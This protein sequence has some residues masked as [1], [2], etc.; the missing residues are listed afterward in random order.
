MAGGTNETR[1]R[2]FGVDSARRVLKVLLLFSGDSPK[3]SAEEIARHVDI[4]VPSAYRFISLLR[5]MNLLTD[6]GGGEYAL[7]PRA[8]SLAQAA[9]HALEGWPELTRLVEHLSAATGEAALVI[10]RVSDYATC[11]VMSQTE[12]TIR[13]S[14]TPGQMMSLHRG[15]GA[16]LL[17]AEMGEEWARRYFDRVEPRMLAAERAALT[18]DLAKIAAQGWSQSAAEVDE[19]VWAVAAPIRIGGR[20]LAAVSVAGPQ[21][22]IDARRGAEI[23][24]EVVK[25]AAEVT[26]T[27]TTHAAS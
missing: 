17:L 15:A 13:L 1:G 3:R 10:Q 22:R 7:S 6:A 21:Y 5:E 9:E 20:L 18:A 16:K 24:D 14:F 27:L 19:E 12:Q 23:L 25:R 2:T 8:F 4:S 26:D 11:A